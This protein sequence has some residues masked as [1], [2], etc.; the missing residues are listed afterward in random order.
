M[1]HCSI[2]GTHNKNVFSD[3]RLDNHR[4]CSSAGLCQVGQELRP[5]LH[6]HQV[7]LVVQAPS[8]DFFYT[9]CVQSRRAAPGQGEAV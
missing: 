5:G 9:E 4:D 7:A 6:V 3:S 8:E 2:H 1:R